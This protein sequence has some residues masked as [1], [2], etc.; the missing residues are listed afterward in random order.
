ME[1]K[2][3]R[4][5]LLIILEEV[6]RRH[7]VEHSGLLSAAGPAWL[8]QMPGWLTEASVTLGVKTLS[9]KYVCSYGSSAAA[10]V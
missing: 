6:E 3:P 5:S 4:K 8:E 7:G 2:T 10:R 9:Q 1:L